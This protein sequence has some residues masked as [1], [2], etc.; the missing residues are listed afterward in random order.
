[1]RPLRIRDAGVVDE[2]VDGAERR[3]GLGHA[4]DDRFV[5][6]H[7]QDDRLR[8]AAGAADLLRQ[9]FQPVQPTGCDGHLGAAGGDDFRKAASKAGGCAGDEG[10]LTAQVVGHIGQGVVGH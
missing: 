9:G 8:H 5:V 7:V 1:M 10:H 2:N 4:V 6:L 3:L